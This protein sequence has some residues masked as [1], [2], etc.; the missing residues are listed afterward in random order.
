M[1][2]SSKRQLL[3]ETALFLA[4]SEWVAAGK[5]FFPEL[6]KFL[7][8]TLEMDYI[9]I[10]RLLGDKLTAE[11]VGVY[12]NGKFEDN[13]TYT[14]KDTPCG[15]VVGK[16]ICCFPE[17]VRHLFPRDEVLQDMKAESYIGTTL[18]SYS[19][20]SI[21][22]IAAIGCKPL[23]DVA[24]AESIL[25]LVGVRAAGELERRMAEESLRISEE[26]FKKAFHNSPDIILITTIQD[27]T[28]I[29]VNDSIHRLGGFNKEEII[30]KTTLELELWAEAS[31]R[32]KLVEL[33]QTQGRIMNFEAIFRTKSGE[34]FYGLVSADS[35][36]IGNLKCMLSIIHD[37]D[38]LK[39]AEFALKENES[40]LKD[41]NA[42]KDK[43][44]SIIAHDLRSPLSSILGF[45]GLLLEQ[46]GKKNEESSEKYAAIINRSSKRVMNLLANLLEWAK[47]QTGKIEFTPEYLELN[48]LINGVIEL[49][50]GT[51]IQ[52]SITVV[53]DMPAIAVVY[54]DKSMMQTI[55]RNLLSNALK[56]TGTGG[57][58]SV[59]MKER[60]G[61]V[62]IIVKDNGK[63]M[64]K[65]DIDKLFRIDQSYSTPDTENEKGSGLGLILSKEFIEKHG[66]Q[67]I[68]KSEPDKGSE[69]SFT[70][71][72]A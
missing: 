18:W 12:Y 57:R 59:S 72:V 24:L 38:A 15:D 67:I 31:D 61:Q 20:R 10:D 7:S 26:K 68:I 11:T 8:E 56:F 53:L 16:T 30:G 13:V 37:I 66:G 21:G 49:L 69:F 71:P 47:M 62:E 51:A 55:L 5:D 63:G 48:S 40:R 14:L 9:C 2:T 17:N 36:E 33:L 44:F 42:T 32:K 22:L 43:F 45:S 60:P 23:K 6:A 65:R 58:V 29:E 28:I 52:K 39:R 27:G 34:I 50:S 4:K 1:T 54:A 70:V 19:G 46:I 41:L 25:N 64:S 3:Q 35:F